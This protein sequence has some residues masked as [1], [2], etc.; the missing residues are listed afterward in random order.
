MA[1]DGQAP[2]APDR[3]LRTV[4][5]DPTRIESLAAEWRSLASEAA[6]SPFESPDWL[7]PWFRHYGAGKRPLVLAWR[8]A[9]RLVAIAPLIAWEERRGGLPLRN[10]AFWG[11]THTPLRGWVDLLARDDDRAEVTADFGGWLADPAT[12]WDLLHGLRLPAGS[13]TP[14]A[15]AGGPWSRVSLTGVVQSV[16]FVLD[17]PAD[18]EG[19]TG[20]L[21]RKAR[22]NIRREARLFESELGGRFERLSDPAAVPVVVEALRRLLALRWG[23]REAYFRADPSFEGF[24]AEALAS[25]FA[26]GSAEA[27]LALEPGGVD[28]CLVTMTLNRSTVTLFVAISGDPGLGRFSLGKN[29][30]AQSLDAAVEGRSTVF[31]FLAVGEYKEAF[32]GARG[33]E[34]DTSLLGRGPRGRAVVAYAR[35]RRLIL[36]GIARR[37]RRARGP[38]ADR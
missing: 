11:A 26:V 34:L 27:F 14:A 7:L 17:I 19:W 10:L 30:F 38:G 15:L 1:P 28:G 5:E 24:L 31:N 33:R 20:P 37:L 2:A 22:Y 6:R 36:P 8:R 13:S 32:W 4:L 16:E 9:G 23:A 29:L 35:V 25:T 12:G 3:P 18:P 21:G